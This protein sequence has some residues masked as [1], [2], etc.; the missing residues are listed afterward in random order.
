MMPDISLYLDFTLK[1]FVTFGAI[2]EV[3]IVTIVVIW[4]GITTREALIKAR[5]YVIVGAFIVGML[6]SPPDV[7]SQ[8]L[9]A[10]PLCLLFELG[11]LL[12]PFFSP[13]LLEHKK[14]K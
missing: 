2:F 5:P 8:I 6:L 13:H 12:S 3:P 11:L 14:N 10:V 1:L 9:L 7:L 4:T